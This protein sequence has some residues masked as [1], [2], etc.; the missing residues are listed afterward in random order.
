M[1]INVE[2]YGTGEPIVFIHG[3]GEVHT[4]GIIKENI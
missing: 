4:I 3:V 2:I 1:N